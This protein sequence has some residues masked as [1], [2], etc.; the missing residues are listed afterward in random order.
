MMNL[1]T[2]MIVEN[3]IPNSSIVIICRIVEFI[4]SVGMFRLVR[5]E[6]DTLSNEE[7]IKRDL[8]WA[9]P[10]ENIYYHDES[11]NICHKNGLVTF[12]N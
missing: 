12:D 10:S 7:L 3:R 8:T 6:D 5:V 9:C 11:C 4:E 1:K 2:G